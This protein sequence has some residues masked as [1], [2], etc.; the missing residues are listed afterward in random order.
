MCIYTGFYGNHQTLLGVRVGGPAVS[1]SHDLVRAMTWFQMK[2]M[3]REQLVQQRQYIYLHL[4][5]DY[6]IFCSV[7]K[8]ATGGRGGYL[9]C[10]RYLTLLILLGHRKPEV[11]PRRLWVKGKVDPGQD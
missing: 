11:Y 6:F 1:A 2:T 3:L 7:T 8:F 5:K 4:V 10:C 9:V